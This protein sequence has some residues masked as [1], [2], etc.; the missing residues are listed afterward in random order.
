MRECAVDGI[1]IVRKVAYDVSRS[2]CIKIAYGESRQLLKHLLSHS[3]YDPLAQIYHY[4]R[5]N[6]RKECRD[7][8]AREHHRNV[9]PYDRE[10]NAALKL[11]SV[12]SRTRISRAEEREL[13]CSKREQK[14]RHEERPL[15]QNVFAKAQEDALSSLFI[16]WHSVLISQGKHLPSANR[17]SPY[18][19]C[20]SQEDARACRI[21]L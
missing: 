15:H 3:V 17:L 5:E 14:R 7:R 16:F 9:F 8:V 19:H 20:R 11:N 1:N 2:V 12:D 18:I 21:R 4:D 13:I 10:I 6:I